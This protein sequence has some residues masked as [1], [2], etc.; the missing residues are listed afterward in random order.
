MDRVCLIGA[1]GD[2]LIERLPAA[3]L[4]R[5]WSALVIEPARLA[6]PRVALD[7]EQLWVD[8]ERIGAIVFRAATNAPFSASFPEDDHAFC[9]AETRA[10][11]LGALH[12]PGVASFN[13]LDAIA[14]FETEH[15]S[16]WRRVLA[17]R[18]VPL[19]RCEL[20]YAREERA[21]VWLPFSSSAIQADPG[22]TVARASGAARFAEQRFA[23]SLVACGRVVSGPRTAAVD[24][25]TLE[26]ARAG[27]RLAA[28]ATGED[29]RVAWVDTQPQ[30]LSSSDA[31]AVAE[32]IAAEIAE[33][34][35]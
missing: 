21:R 11:W 20:G 12:L 33:R 6:D 16:V 35:R 27:V 29:G 34:A 7:A 26:L 5:G 10:V 22:E 25:A 4:R 14:W 8:G 15:W 19:A 3:L 9:D 1:A 28:I 31:E 24:T 2:P 18:G 32:L 13:R 30:A 17:R 23:S